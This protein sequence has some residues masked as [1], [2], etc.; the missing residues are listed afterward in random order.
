MNVELV[1]SGGEFLLKALGS[2]GSVSY[3]VIIS[4]CRGL[5]PNSEEKRTTTMHIT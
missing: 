2:R 1:A 5:G 3:I 4:N